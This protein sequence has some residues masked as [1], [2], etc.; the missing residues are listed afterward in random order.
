LALISVIVLN[1]NGTKHDYLAACLRSLLGQSLMPHQIVVVDNGSE[2]NSVVFVRENF[3]Q[4]T[5]IAAGQNLG[6]CAGNNLGY[7]C[8]T[9]DFVLFANNDTL[10][11]ADALERLVEGSKLAAN[12]GMV[13]PKLIRPCRPGESSFR[14]DSGGLMLQ[15]DLTLRDRGFGEA[16]LGRYETPAFLFAPCGAAAFY[17]QAALQEILHRDG[18]LWDESFVAYYEDGDLAWRLQNRGWR[19]LY[20]P[21]AVVEHYR[22]GSSAATFFKKP[23]GF[24]VHTIKNRY[25]MLLKNASPSLLVR[26]LPYLIVREALIAGYLALHPGLLL[27][28]WRAFIQSAPSA[29]QKR[30]VMKPAVSRHHLLNVRPLLLN[31]TDHEPTD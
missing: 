24:K 3:P 19:C 9:G 2:D 16:D 18:T 8:A 15:A 6:F 30:R 10:F 25:L 21:S 31:E 1:Y 13:A 26:Q 20:Y 23:L 12:I 7:P 11:R 29:R 14:L 22:G 27:A 5:L 17:R 28:V 4:V